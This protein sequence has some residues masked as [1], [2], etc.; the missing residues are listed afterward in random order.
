MLKSIK[1]AISE[2]KS[3]GGQLLVPVHKSHEPSGPQFSLLQD[4]GGDVVFP[5]WL[6]QSTVKTSGKPRSL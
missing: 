6:N 2:F 3:L 4:R 1:E 5:G